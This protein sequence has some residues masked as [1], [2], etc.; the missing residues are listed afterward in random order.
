LPDSDLKFSLILATVGRTEDVANFLAHLA[1]QSYRCFELVV[2]DQNQDDRLTPVLA[3]YSARFPLQRCRS[4]PGLSLARN[5]GLKRANG[6]V[7]AFPDDDCWYPPDLLG[8]V[9]HALIVHPELGGVTGRPVD[10]S[11][12]RFHKDSGPINKHNVFLR[13]SSVTMFLR[14]SV[15]DAVGE[16]DENLGVGSTGGRIA[17][18]ETDYLLRALE[19]GFQF[20]FDADIEVF[21]RE[22][23]LLY[24]RKSDR[25]ARAY[26]T[27]LGYLLRK[28]R[29]PFW[30]VGRTWLRSLGGA[31]VSVLAWNFPKARYHVAVLEGRIAGWLNAKRSTNK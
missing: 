29:Y 1:S 26:N 3:S 7:I 28:Y 21:H 17:G 4:A 20:Y 22:P 16:F 5:V 9:A 11:F 31:G 27:A 18:E 23:A 13:C 19:A 8:R 12:S 10:R 24:D 6:N 14:R 15:V 2:V 25:K 30:Y